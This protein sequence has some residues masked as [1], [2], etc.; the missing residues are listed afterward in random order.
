[1]KRRIIGSLI[2]CLFV[3]GQSVMAQQ[4]LGSHNSGQ[5]KRVSLGISVG[6]GMDWLVPRSDS[7]VMQQA[8]P[9]ATLRY[10]IPV[11]INFTK[12]NN[13][14]LTTG[15]YFQHLGG[16]SKL[17][18]FPYTSITGETVWPDQFVRTYR[19]IYL[20]IPVGIKL[21]TPDF[22]NF[23]FVANFGLQQSFAIQAKAIDKVTYKGVTE[24]ME[25]NN[26]Y[27]QT[28]FFREAGYIGLGLEYIIKDDFRVWL[29][30]NYAYS[31]TNYFAYK[32]VLKEKGNIMSL[33]ITVGCNF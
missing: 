28:A 11:D 3:I 25:N 20:T 10:G 6:S 7:L 19:T 30:A 24:T 4:K 26:Y 2:L 12:A 22:S 5:G 14:Y 16:K 23:V 27:K 33:E 13:Y 1:M 17:L 32:N 9:I 31:F 18:N 8:G 29:N 21:K 15:I